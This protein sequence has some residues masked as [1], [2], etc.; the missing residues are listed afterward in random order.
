MVKLIDCTYFTKGERSILNAPLSVDACA[1]QAQIAVRDAIDGY[2]ETLQDEFLRNAIGRLT[3][4]ILSEYLELKEAYLEA[5]SAAAAAEETEEN[6]YEETD[7]EF[8][9]DDELELLASALREPFADFVFYRILR[10]SRH[11]PT[12]TGLVQLKCANDYVDP[13]RRQTDSWNNMVRRLLDFLENVKPQ[14]HGCTII[15]SWNYLK[16][17]NALNL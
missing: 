6:E 10:A 9:V 5:Q 11:Q 2:I 14:I 17:I 3:A 4:S 8:E 13:A 7:S 1:D 15:V 16:P 12:I